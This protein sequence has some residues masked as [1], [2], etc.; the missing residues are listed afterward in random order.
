MEEIDDDEREDAAGTDR[1]EH[2]VLEERIE[3]RR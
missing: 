2:R 3:K 1:D